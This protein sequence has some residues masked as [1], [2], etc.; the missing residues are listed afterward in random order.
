MMPCLPIDMTSS[1]TVFEIELTCLSAS[2]TERRIDSRRIMASG[3]EKTANEIGF[4][5]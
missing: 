2:A 4:G 3:F 5:R 1:M